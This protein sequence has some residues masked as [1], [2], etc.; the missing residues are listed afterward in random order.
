MSTPYDAEWLEFDDD[1]RPE[2][3]CPCPEC[4]GAVPWRHPHPEE[5]DDSMMEPEYPGHVAPERQG[6]EGWWDVPERRL[7]T[8]L[9]G[10]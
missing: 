2:W 8:W 10:R 4:N 7:V 6:L 9:G 3:Q 5:D 1:V